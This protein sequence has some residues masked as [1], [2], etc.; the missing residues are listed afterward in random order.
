MVP[1]TIPLVPHTS[2][3]GRE[4]LFQLSSSSHPYP[5]I[6]KLRVRRGPPLPDPT[7]ALSRPGRDFSV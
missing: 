4:Q 5:A 7:G 1:H 2:W 6:T 3:R